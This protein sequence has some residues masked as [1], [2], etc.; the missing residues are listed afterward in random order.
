LTSKGRAKGILF[1]AFGQV[2]VGEGIYNGS[3]GSSEFERSTVNADGTL[4][5]WNGLTGSNVP[6]ANVYNAGA[7]VSPLISPAQTPRFLFLGGQGFTGT[8]GPG[9]T[10]SSTVYVNDAP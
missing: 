2:I 1:S 4:A 3:S 8:T 6:S 5:S 7:F 9:G 10:L